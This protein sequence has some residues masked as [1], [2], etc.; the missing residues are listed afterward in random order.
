ME[1]KIPTM[2]DDYPRNLKPTPAAHLPNMNLSEREL[3]LLNEVGLAATQ[4]LD[5]E[6]ILALAL[7]TFLDKLGMAVVMIYLRDPRSGRYTLRASHGILQEQKD[8][9]ERR[10]CS[11]HDITQQVVDTGQDVFVP[12]MSVDNRFEGLWDHLEGRSYVKL[13]LISRGTVVGVLGLVT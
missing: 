9:I 8:E 5:M 1:P 13:P 12:D 6:E 2:I 3:T 10:R 4:L 7:D 11:G